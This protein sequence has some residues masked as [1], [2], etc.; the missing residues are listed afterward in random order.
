M[1]KTLYLLL[2][3]FA[4]LVSCNSKLQT[5]AAQSA[6]PLPNYDTLKANIRQQQAAIRAAYLQADTIM[7][8]SLVTVTQ[9]YLLRIITTDLFQ[10]WYNTPWD[11]NGIT[12]TPGK[13]K[14]ACGYFVTSVLAD[15]GFNIPR[16]AWAQLAS[17][18]M[19]KKLNPAV[20]KFSNK[21]IEEFEAY[22]KSKSDG[23]Y[24]VGLDCHVGFVSKV[25]GKLLFT[26]SSYYQPDIGVMSEELQGHNPL[27]DSKYRV[28]G[29]M[30]HREMVVNWIM[31]N[32]YQ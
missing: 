23:L 14:L 8:D 30:L 21:T 4:L 32:K 17:E 22:V 7:R 25:K 3:G 11:F 6:Q 31:G 19:I 1:P 29:P 24:I 28:L 13:G 9:Q 5:V 2:I 20:K 12:N 16:L 10:Q 15:A 26:H 18:T 27:N